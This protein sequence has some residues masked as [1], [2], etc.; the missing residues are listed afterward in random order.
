MNTGQRIDDVV[1]IDITG[2]EDLDNAVDSSVTAGQRKIILDLKQREIIDN[3]L[4]TGKSG[5]GVE[6][7]SAFL[8]PYRKVKPVDGEVVLIN[9]SESDYRSLVTIFHLGSILVIK[10]TLEDALEYLDSSK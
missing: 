1:I 6:A 10:D 3:A 2:L 8:V 4:R 5:R 7:A 9:M